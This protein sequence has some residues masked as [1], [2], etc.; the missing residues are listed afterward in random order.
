MFTNLTLTYEHLLRQAESEINTWMVRA[1]CND[2]LKR[3]RVQCR[4]RAIGA[5]WLWAS[6]TTPHV[7][8]LGT[9]VRAAHAVAAARLFE[10][11]GMPEQAVRWRAAPF[12]QHRLPIMARDH[13][14]PT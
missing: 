8:A 6:L 9:G 10:R 7:N 11:V 13:A 3:E 12:D 14:A 1:E 4:E 5:L 2:L